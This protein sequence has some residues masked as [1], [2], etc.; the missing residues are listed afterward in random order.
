M[1]NGSGIPGPFGQRTLRKYLAYDFEVALFNLSGKEAFHNRRYRSV[2][3]RTS[4][5]RESQDGRSGEKSLLATLSWKIIFPNHPK[6][7]RMISLRS[8]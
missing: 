4:T 7:E 8:P 2:F 5:C 6:G 3:A 1:D